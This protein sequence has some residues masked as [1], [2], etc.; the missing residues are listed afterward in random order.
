MALTLLSPPV[1]GDEGIPI[2]KAIGRPNDFHFLHGEWKIRNRRLSSKEA[3]T[4]DEFDGEATCWSILSGIASIEEL[5]IPSRN[6]F[7]MGLRILDVEKRIWN[8]FWINARSG[9]LT[10]PGQAGV[11]EN[12][13]GTFTADDVDGEKPIKVRGVWDQ[14]TPDSCRWSQAVSY[15]QG[16]SWK[17]NWIMNWTRVK[18]IS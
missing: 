8:D 6:F 1:D 10:T 14:I 18:T 15:D 3:D 16:Q 12:G 2:S 7:G 5:R 17:E 11:F 13:V 4:W 9:I